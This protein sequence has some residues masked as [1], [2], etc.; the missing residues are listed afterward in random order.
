[1]IL[2][3]SCKTEYSPIPCIQIEEE[4]EDLRYVKEKLITFY[5]ID[6]NGY[7]LFV[8][9]KRI[10][11]N[12]AGLIESK[13]ERDDLS[14]E[15]VSILHTNGIIYDKNKVIVDYYDDRKMSKFSSII[16]YN[17]N[18][19]KRD[20]LISDSSK[21]ITNEKYTYDN[22]NREILKELNFGEN[23]CA[24]VEKKYS[25][26]GNLSELKISND[27]NEFHLYKFFP[28][29]SNDSFNCYKFYVNNEFRSKKYLQY[30]SLNNPIKV[31]TVINDKLKCLET[32]VYKYHNSIE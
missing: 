15:F 11:Y 24:T 18:N 12:H 27:K 17:T 3:L 25:D 10:T 1:M 5:E 23:Y 26:E 4:I 22:Q 29:E 13:F 2:I 19:L 14:L 7:E 31:K 20:I 16:N 6:S 9:Q 28:D 32:I 30:D 8:N 21:M